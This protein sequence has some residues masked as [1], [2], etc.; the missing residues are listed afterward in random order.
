MANNKILLIEDNVDMRENTAEI[1]ELANYEVITAENGKMGVEIAQKELPDLIICDI[2]MPMLDGYGVLYLLSKS[3]A[4]ASIPFIFLTAK[5]ERADIRKGMNLGADDYLTKPFD[6]ME[7]LNAIESRLKKSEII[8]KHFNQDVEGINSFF[9]EAVENSAVRK[10]SENRKVKKYKKKEIIFHEDSVPNGVYFISK[11]KVKGFKTNEDAK[12][13]IT[14]LYGEGDFFGHMPLLEQTQYTETAMALEESEICFIPKED[15]FEI[16]NT[17]KDVSYKFIK[18]LANNL[19]EKEERLLNLAYN[20][21]RQRVAEALLLLAEH[22]QKEESNS[23]FTIAITREDLANIV[24][25]STESV[26]RT[27][28]DF[29]DEELIV[30]KGRNVE[31]L[32]LARLRSVMN[33]FY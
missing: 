17:S 28:A 10:L 4:T 24:G 33:G 7:L 19:K 8:H 26:I 6:D 23:P 9:N 22:Y 32:D 20:T 29:K 30:I 21:V 11:G 3:T 16:M 18:I 14:G 2:M 31:I 25:T 1:L 5:A 12:E 13:Y 27:L 15:F